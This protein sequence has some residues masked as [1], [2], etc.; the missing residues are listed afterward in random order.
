MNKERRFVDNDIT[1]V[2][3]SPSQYV[4]INEKETKRRKMNER[5]TFCN[6][7]ACR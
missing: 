7:L 6:P 4:K 2:Q 1:R 3:N 5:V